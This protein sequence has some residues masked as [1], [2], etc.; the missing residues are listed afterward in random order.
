MKKGGKWR[1]KENENHKLLVHIDEKIDSLHQCL[2]VLYFGEHDH[3]RADIIHGMRKEVCYLRD[4]LFDLLFDGR[5]AGKI[6]E[7][8]K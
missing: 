4:I 7:N 2:K 5:L 1:P 6:L 8:R 3:T